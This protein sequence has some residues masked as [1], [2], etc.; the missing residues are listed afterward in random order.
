MV[1]SAE[2]TAALITGGI[3]A[4]LAAYAV[5]TGRNNVKDLREIIAAL[6]ERIDELEA[7]NGDLKDWAARL[8]EQLIKAGVKPVDF[9]RRKRERDGD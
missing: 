3:A 7:D 8:V 5:I 6:R 9:I 1:V 2:I 4:I